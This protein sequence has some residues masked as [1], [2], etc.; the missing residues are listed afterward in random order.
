MPRRKKSVFSNQYA[1]AQAV[2]EI[3]LR[4]E[5]PRVLTYRGWYSGI[6]FSD[7]SL[8]DGTERTAVFMPD[9][10]E[11]SLNVL[12]S[13]GYVPSSDNI[14]REVHNVWVAALATAEMGYVSTSRYYQVNA[15]DDYRKWNDVRTKAWSKVKRV[16]VPPN[17]VFPMYQPEMLASS[18]R[19]SL[20][21]I[22]NRLP[23]LA[24][25]KAISTRDR[26]EWQLG[27]VHDYCKMFARPVP[28]W[29]D[30]VVQLITDEDV[31]QKISKY[32]DRRKFL[33][34]TSVARAMFRKLMETDPSR[35]HVINQ[36]V[37][38]GKKPLNMTREEIEKL[39]DALT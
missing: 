11:E 23:S 14:S 26:I 3:L 20:I 32:K 27:V 24:P 16:Y 37:T 10:N 30:Q 6:E 12:V 1:F 9:L 34:D 8:W 4:H 28:E 22:A 29:Y 15:D 38:G 2:V 25:G 31:E 7:N 36:T 5:E 19:D 21:K 17:L 13:N 35:Y 18:Y 39:R 33:D